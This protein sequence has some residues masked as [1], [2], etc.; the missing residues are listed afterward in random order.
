MSHTFDAVI[1]GAGAPGEH[2]AERLADAGLSTAICE[3]ELVAG[4]CHFWACI[5]SKTLLRPGEVLSEARQAP[6]AREAVTGDLD[7]GEA[8][9][10]RDFMVEATKGTPPQSFVEPQPFGVVLN[11]T[12]TAPSTTVEQQDNQQPKPTDPPGFPTP[13]SLPGQPQ[14]SLPPQPGPGPGP[15]RP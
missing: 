14:T 8:F 6:G 9:S 7:A 5:P 3:R 2:L 4:E 11:A 15:T 13:T 1:I 12:T 10:W